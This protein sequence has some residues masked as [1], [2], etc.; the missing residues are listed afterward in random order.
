MVDFP[1]P[2]SPTSPRVSPL[3]MSK[4]TLSTALTSP[5]RW[6]NTPPVIGKYF[7]SF[8]T[9]IKTSPAGVEDVQRSRRGSP[10]SMFPPASRLMGVRDFQEHG[11]LL[12]ATV[13]GIFA[14]WRKGA[15][16]RASTCPAAALISRVA[17]FWSSR[18]PT[19]QGP[20]IGVLRRSVR[21]TDTSD[22]TTWPPYM[23]TTLSA[24][25]AITPR[26]G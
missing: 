18:G 24:R 4:V 9:L 23:T 7:F 17:P 10:F 16:G 19:E 25:L 2:L 3:R 11:I 5:M 1:D 20:R 13:V 26:S 14:P 21:L 12:Q 6:R 22:S 8:L 15:A